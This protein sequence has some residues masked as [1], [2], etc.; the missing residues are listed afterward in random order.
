MC[1]YIY[2]YRPDM[3]PLH[4]Q[5]DMTCLSVPYMICLFHAGQAWKKEISLWVLM[6]KQELNLLG[7]LHLRLTVT[8]NIY[9]Y[10]RYIYH[11]LQGPPHQ[12]PP[13]DTAILW[14][15]KLAKI[16][17]FLPILALFPKQTEYWVI[18]LKIGKVALFRHCFPGNLLGSSWPFKWSSGLNPWIGVS[19]GFG[20]T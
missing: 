12:P 16:R 19:L 17:E 10:Y 20:A 9:I 2:L 6:T 18:S 1:I 13:G 7:W 4:A 3:L 11:R 8:Y 5:Y 14:W 15:P